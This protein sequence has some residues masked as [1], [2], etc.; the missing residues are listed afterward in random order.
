MTIINKSNMDNNDF[1]DFL[2]RTN[3]ELQD[4]TI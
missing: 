2:E 1:E 3:L 4:L